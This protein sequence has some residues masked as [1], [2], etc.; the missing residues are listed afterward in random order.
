M[1][2]RLQGFTPVVSLMTRIVASGNQ[3][4]RVRLDLDGTP[5]VLTVAGAKS[6]TPGAVNLTDGGRYPNN[7]YFGAITPEGAFKPARAAA[8]LDPAIKAML[9]GT[10]T[11]IRD[12]EAEAVFAEAGKRLGKCC[13]CGR[14]LSDQESVER[15]IGPICAERAFG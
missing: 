8:Q 9:W 12:G 13:M 2:S 14:D 6:R 3:F 5:L 10:L 4:P 1:D 15:G 7:T 11:R